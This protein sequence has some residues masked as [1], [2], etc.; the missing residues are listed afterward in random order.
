MFID[1][2]CVT[3]ASLLGTKA[4][5]SNMEDCQVVYVKLVQ[6]WAQML[7]LAKLAKVSVPCI[8]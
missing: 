1:V 7:L 6:E 8:E 4:L 2:L 3:C 5:G